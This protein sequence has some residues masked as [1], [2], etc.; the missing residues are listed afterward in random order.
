MTEAATVDP[1]NTSQLPCGQGAA[2]QSKAVTVFL[3]GEAVTEN[4]RHMVRLYA[5]PVIG[6]RYPHTARLPRNAYYHLFVRPCRCFAGILRVAQE[7]D[8]NLQDLMFF[9]EK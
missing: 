3:C 8:Q 6:D 5:N 1:Q 2:V 7:I 9:N 4:S